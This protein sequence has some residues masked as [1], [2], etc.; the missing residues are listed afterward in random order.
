LAIAEFLQFLRPQREDQQH[1][2]RVY[3]AHVEAIDQRVRE[4]FD[5]W[6]AQR[7]VEPDYARLANSAAVHRWELMRLGKRAERLHPP[8]AFNRAHADLVDVVTDCAR[9]CQLL[10]NGY[11]FYKSEAICD[12]QALFVDTLERLDHLVRTVSAA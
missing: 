1:T 9:A 4:I 8:R 12:G 2:A 11:R 7:E 3:R 5:A 10:A 6:V